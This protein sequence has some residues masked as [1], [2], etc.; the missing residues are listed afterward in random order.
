MIT[1]KTFMNSFREMSFVPVVLV[2]LCLF[3]CKSMRKSVDVNVDEDI[4]YFT[5]VDEYPLFDGLSAEKGFREFM[6]KNI[7]YPAVAVLNNNNITGYVFVEFIVE[8]DGSVKHAKAIS[9]ASRILQTE[10]LRAVKSSPKWTPGK[11]DGEP[12]RMRYTIPIDFQI[13]NVNA[14][15]SSKKVE[16]SEETILLDEIEIMAIGIPSMIIRHY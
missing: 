7:I 9:R 16:L 5:N 14:K 6:Q 1:K 8:K 11:I 2:A 12:V 10:A 3:S 13:F 4:I 15:S